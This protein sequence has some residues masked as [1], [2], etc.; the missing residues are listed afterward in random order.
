MSFRSFPSSKF[1]H[2]FLGGDVKSIWNR[3]LT[4]GGG[5]GGGGGGSRELPVGVKEKLSKQWYF[6][7]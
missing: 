7:W 6:I 2:C 1:D 5:G 3:S 4:E